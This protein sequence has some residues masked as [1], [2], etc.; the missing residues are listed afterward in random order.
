MNPEL[1]AKDLQKPLKGEYLLERKAQRA[2]RVADEQ[3]VMQDAKKRDGGK[4]R[5]PNCE[6]AK[7]DL[8]IDVCHFF[9]R[10]MGGN[11]AGDRT[12]REQLISMC[13]IHHSLFDR[14]DLDVSPMTSAQADGPCAYSRARRRERTRQELIQRDEQ[15][16]GRTFKAL[17]LFGLIAMLACFGVALHAFTHWYWGSGK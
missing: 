10:G 7:R 8:P 11:P 4:C 13:R 9:H 3:K 5:I 6:Y 15:I 2:K 14:G 12:T 1:T 17:A 16:M